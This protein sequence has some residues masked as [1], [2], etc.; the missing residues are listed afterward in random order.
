MWLREATDVLEPAD[1]RI[2]SLTFD[3]NPAPGGEPA[4]GIVTFTRALDEDTLVS[5]S[6]GLPQFASVPSQVIA[7]AGATQITFPVETS[8]PEVD[9]T[10]T[11]FATAFAVTR[12]TSLTVLAPPPPPDADTVRITR[13]EYKNSVLRVEATSTSS[14]ATLAV[15][16]LSGS[17]IF[18]LTNLG[19]GKY[20][21]EQPLRV[22]PSTIL[23]SSSLGGSDTANVTMR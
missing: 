13:A 6:S 19:S 11:M 12:T 8:P 10:F 18:T 23:V 7:P 14:N 4:I 22:S 16:H 2:S 3:P 9:R 15:Y 17:R 1:P 21:G 5:L 20:R